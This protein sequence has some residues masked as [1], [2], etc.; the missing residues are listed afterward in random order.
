MLRWQPR[1]TELAWAAAAAF[2]ATVLASATATTASCAATAANE[3]AS[4]A[5]AEATAEL[6]RGHARVLV[7]RGELGEALDAAARAV[8][9]APRDAQ[10]WAL[11]ASLHSLAGHPAE[12]R[13]S[14]R[15]CVVHAPPRA[16]LECRVGAR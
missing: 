13:A 16:I 11:L 2:T 4:H 6:W 5:A 3:D 10:S 8:E 9:H 15:A 1:A 14:R 7:E 12:A